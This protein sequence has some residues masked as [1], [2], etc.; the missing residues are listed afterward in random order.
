MLLKITAI[1]DDSL[2]A[3]AAKR[4]EGTRVDNGEE[5]S[6]KFFADNRA[7]REQL[8]D[9]GIGDIANVKLVQKG[10]HWNIESLTVPTESMIQKVK[11]SGGKSYTS[12]GA[13][14]SPSTGGTKSTWN[15]RTGEAY[16]RSAAIY[17]ALDIAKENKTAKGRIELD[18]I[19]K[20][21][22]QVFDYINKGINP[23][24]DPLSPPVE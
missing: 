15:G 5:W 11:D 9:F 1:E 14:A 21:A 22:D 12:G 8:N 16:D 23:F 10:K 13:A 17:L 3:S 20:T 4:I 6:K 7:L 2:G 24:D 18:E 19:M